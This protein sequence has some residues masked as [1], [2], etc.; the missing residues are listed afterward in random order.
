MSDRK[1]SL[2]TL[3]SVL[4]TIF[5]VR[6]HQD[7]E[8]PLSVQPWAHT[9]KSSG[10]SPTKRVRSSTSKQH[11]RKRNQMARASRRKNRR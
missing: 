10:R 7:L 4:P 2:G 11:S 5:P 8:L 1:R 6:T 3:F 9:S